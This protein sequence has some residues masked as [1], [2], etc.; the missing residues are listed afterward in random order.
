MTTPNEARGIEHGP[1]AVVVALEGIR[2]A[3]I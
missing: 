1:F 3:L 2:R